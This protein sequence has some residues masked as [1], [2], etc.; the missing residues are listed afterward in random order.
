MRSLCFI[1]EVLNLVV[2]YKSFLIFKTEGMLH[3]NMKT[4]LERQPTW[5]NTFHNP[6]Y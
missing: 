6:E 5:K 3:F 1:L 2:S 4:V